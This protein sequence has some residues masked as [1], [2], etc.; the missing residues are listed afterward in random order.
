MFDEFDDSIERELTRAFAGTQAPARLRA[1][2]MHRV[3]M[4]PPTRMPEVLDLIGLMSILSFAA[5]FAFF[6]ILK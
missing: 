3:H 5:C 6:V 4:P 1:A 2:V